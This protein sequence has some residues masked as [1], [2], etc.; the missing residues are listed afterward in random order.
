MG[1]INREIKFRAWDDQQKYMAYQGE[2][3]LET[4]QSFMFHYGDKKLMQYTGFKD[5]NGKEIYEGDILRYTPY[6]AR[7]KPRTEIVRFNISCG[8]WYIGGQS[9]TL[10][11]L[12]VEQHDEEWQ[13]LQN[14][15]PN[16]EHKVVVVGNIYE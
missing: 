9:I 13:I 11:Y 14:Y 16:I 7:L 1:E 5:Y 12:F 3:D 6:M 8:C 15:K 4:I 2:P 10:S